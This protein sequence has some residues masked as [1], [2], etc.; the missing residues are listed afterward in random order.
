M[1]NNVINI[2]TITAVL[3]KITTI[4]EIRG[5]SVINEITKIIIVI[6][7]IL[8]NNVINGILVNKNNE[9][10]NSNTMVIIMVVMFVIAEDNLIVANIMILMNI[11]PVD[12]NHLMNMNVLQQNVKL[13]SRILKKRVKILV[14]CSLSSCIVVVIRIS[15]CVLTNHY[16][17]LLI[18]LQ[19]SRKNPDPHQAI[20]MI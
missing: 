1:I 18:P 4:T 6:K 3:R 15:I 2:T 17:F 8:V 7:D 16:Y 20:K 13:L 11:V 14:Y 9:I 10:S 5:V 19:K 12:Q